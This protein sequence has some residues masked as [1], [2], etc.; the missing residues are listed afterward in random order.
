M[1]VLPIES[2]ENKVNNDKKDEEVP[3]DLS[4]ILKYMK[5]KFPSFVLFLHICISKYVFICESEYSNETLDIIY[6]DDG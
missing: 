1:K 6:V 5:V 2:S 4:S 3:S